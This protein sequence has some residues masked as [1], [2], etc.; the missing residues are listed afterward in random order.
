MPTCSRD[1]VFHIFPV[2]SPRRDALRQHLSDCGIETEIHYPIPPHKQVC[3]RA[4]N[5]LSYPLTEQIAREELSLPLHPAM[6]DAEVVQ[7]TEALNAFPQ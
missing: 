7:V 2:L 1:S 4:W 3:Y 6:T 5:H